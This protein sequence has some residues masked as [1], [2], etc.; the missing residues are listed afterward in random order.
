MTIFPALV[1]A[2]LQRVRHPATNVDI[3]S[4][5]LVADDVR[6]EGQRVTFSLVME[7]PNDPALAEI[8]RRC[9]SSLR[10]ALGPDARVDIL[11]KLKQRA[12]AGPAELPGVA[13]T[14]AIA[15]GKGGVGKST[16]TANLA[17]ALARK[18]L[19]VGVLDA[20]IFGPSM[21]IM[22]GCEDARP[23]AAP[24]STEE[25][26][27]IEPVE[28]Y[29]VRLLSI[30]FF[31]DPGQA[32]VW[33]G[34]MATNAIRQLVTE[35]RWGQLDYLLIDLPPGTS[36]IQI[37]LVGLLKLTAALIVTTP[38]KV[39]VA[40]A[41]KA[42]DMFVNPK[43]AVPVAGVVENMSWFEP[44]EHPGERYLLFGEGGGARLAEKAGRPLLAQIPL[45]AAIGRAADQGEPIALR[46]GNAAADAFRRLADTLH[47]SL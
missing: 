15:S 17:L 31:V 36:D 3:V 13:R 26:Q 23:E 8:K 42:L 32:V 19:R 9:L 20:D 47:D 21:P 28:A 38:Q 41:A 27:L 5:G 46:D 37:S 2:A 29:G 11:V 1:R 40:D 45:V 16:V 14:I 33:R 30:G 35:T 24:G 4:M 6:I 22:F 34:A 25:R 44:L 18:G 43:V 12:P 7:R 39:A 10:E